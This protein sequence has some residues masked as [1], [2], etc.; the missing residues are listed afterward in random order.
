MKT[1]KNQISNSAAANKTH[2]IEHIV[3][4]QDNSAAILAAGDIAIDRNHRF[5][6]IQAAG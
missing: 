5:G 1:C 2:Y 3:L 4:F 6:R